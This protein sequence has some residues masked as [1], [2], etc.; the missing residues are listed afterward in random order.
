MIKIWLTPEK[1]E[2]FLNVDPTAYKHRNEMQKTMLLEYLCPKAWISD[3]S[4][5]K[6]YLPGRICVWGTEVF[7]PTD[8]EGNHSVKHTG[9]FSQWRK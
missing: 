6:L 2:Y 4:L 9:A 8:Q 7:V 1:P 3:G 5:G